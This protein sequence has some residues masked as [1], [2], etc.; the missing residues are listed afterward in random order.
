MPL[1]GHLA[2]GR[3]FADP[4]LRRSFRVQDFVLAA[5]VRVTGPDRFTFADPQ[6]A[7]LI[8]YTVP[9]FDEDTRADLLAQAER[10]A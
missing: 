8:G 4:F 9:R 1:R 5:Y 10:M 6:A 2:D 7:D 3:E